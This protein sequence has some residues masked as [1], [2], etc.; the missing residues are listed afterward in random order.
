MAHSDTPEPST[1][2]LRKIHSITS[3]VLHGCDPFSIH[4]HVRRQLLTSLIFF[5]S[6]GRYLMEWVH[7]FGPKK[8]RVAA[9]LAR[10]RVA[11]AP[12]LPERWLAL[13]NVLTESGELDAALSSLRDAVERLPGA[14]KLRCSLASALIQH[15]AFEEA[16]AQADAA[17]ALAPDDPEIRKLHF[18]LLARTRS[19]D[20]A[21]KSLDAMAGSVAT[22]R[23]IMTQERRLDSAGLLAFCEARLA[24][25]S[26]SSAAIFYKAVALARLGRGEEACAVMSPDKHVAICDLPAPAQYGDGEKFRQLLA[27]EICRN[28]TLAPD[29]RGKATR[30]G[31]QTRHLRQPD[32]V[33]IEALIAQIK[34]AAQDY[35]RRLSASDE[36]FAAAQPK[37]AR[38]DAW[39]VVCG[40]DGRQKAHLHPH[41][42]L[43]GVYYVTASRPAG[44]N[45]YRGPLILGALDPHAHGVEPPW[46]TREIEPVPGRLVLFPSYLPHATQPSGVEG[47]RISVAFDV[48]PAKPQ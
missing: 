36:A 22:S 40:K 47:A 33:A 20:A 15:E 14:A 41:G 48:V 31:R 11:D 46:G 34:H 12:D 45:L 30:D 10:R 25:D 18:E 5:A 16:R 9:E 19:W 38:L 4:W 27:A 35:A 43:S 7:D 13:A 23:A 28:P 3:L 26:A 32:A 17:L 6:H 8:V 2:A 37:L 39:A 24:E 29:P 42:W 44:A 1:T 21:G